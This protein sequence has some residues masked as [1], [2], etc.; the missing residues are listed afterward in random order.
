MRDCDS[1]NVTGPKEKQ[2]SNCGTRSLGSV[3]TD[4]VERGDVFCFGHTE[5]STYKEKKE[6][7]L[8]CNKSLG[9][10]RKK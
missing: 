8:D 3:E 7:K 1:K 6:V 2:N 9:L 10:N 5:V 4:I